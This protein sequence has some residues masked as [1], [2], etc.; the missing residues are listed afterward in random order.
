M[1][2]KFSLF[3]IL[4]FALFMVQQGRIF[5]QT[6]TAGTV[7]AGAGSDVLVPINFSAMNNIGAVTLFILYDPTVLTFNGITNV[8][9]EGTGTLANAMTNPPRV[10]IIW[11]ATSAG[12]NFPNG[13]FLDMQFTFNGGLSVL[14]FNTA[15]EVVDW[16]GNP[17]NVTYVDGS[18]S[19]PAVTFNLTVFLEGAYQIGSDGFMRTD[20]LNAGLLP[21]SQPFEPALPYYGNP[22]PEWYYEG[23]E[24]VSTLPANTVDWVIV[25]LRNAAS[26]AQATSATVVARKACLLMS[27]GTVR[28]LNGTSIPTFYAS[29][30]QGAFVVIWHRNHLGIM[31]ANPIG[32]FGGSYA[33]NFSTGPGQVYGGQAGYK[34]LESNIWGMAAGDINAD[35]QINLS[36]KSNGWTVEAAK[37]GYFG[38]DANLNLHVNN[39]DKN[40]YIIANDGKISGIPD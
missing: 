14:D 13:K 11:S 9:P 22:S 3:I 23:S 40:E 1:K 16:D 5:S 25:E 12:V 31:N 19:A 35:N 6:I 21:T 29:F 26:A 32:G 17:I 34:Q 30:S 38:P 8:V 18:V 27:N 37:T 7:T 28:E 20:L 39:P 15:C 10:G 2:N 24:T 36:D 33:F 4:V